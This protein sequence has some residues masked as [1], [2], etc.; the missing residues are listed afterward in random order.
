MKQMYANEKSTLILVSLLKEFGIKKI[1][2]SPGTTNLSFVA[3]LQCD[4]F[5]E[6]YSCVDERSAAYMAVGMAAESGEPVVITCTGATASRNYIPALTEA[7]YRKLPILAVTGTQNVRRVGQLSSQLIDRSQV[8][9][10]IVRMSVD[11]PIMN[12]AEDLQDITVML[13]KALNALT[14]NGGGPVH[15]NLRTQYTRDFSISELPQVR[16]IVRLGYADIE[17]FPEIPHG[18]IGVFVGSH[19]TFS[20]E[21]TK[22]ID[23]FCASKDAV[24]FCDH[25][26]GYYGDYKVNFSLPAVQKNYSCPLLNL[27]L[28]IHLGEISAEYGTL[29]RLNGC[30]EVWRVSPD[31]EIRDQFRKLKYVFEIDES[32]FFSYYTDDRD[33]RDDE[34]R[35]Y[36]KACHEE[37]ESMISKIPQLPFSNVWIASVLTK[38]LPYGSSLHLGILNST[39]AWNLFLLPPGVTS[40]ANVG[41]F[42][43]DGGV[44][45]LI[46]ASLTNPEKLY[47]GIVGDLAFFYDM[48]SLG[49][50]HVGKNVRLL[51][52]NNGKGTEFRNFYHTG[53]LF[54]DKADEYIAAGGHFGNKSANLVKDYSRDLGFEYITAS[55]KDEFLAEYKQFVDPVIGSHS[56][57]FEV[58][59][60]NQD[61]SD[62]LE[63]M[64]NI[65]SDAQGRN[66]SK[67]KIIMNQAR[68]ILGK[69][70]IAFFK[71]ILN[72]K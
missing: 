55:T 18:R 63:A 50:R 52:V 3:S 70:G 71:K 72:H 38:E 13:N 58:F 14:S 62:A 43:I 49:N 27:D 61:E 24:V 31:G 36:L 34:G 53:S 20:L 42:G 9:R 7:Y 60:N 26:S 28:C 47:F 12:D 35:Q 57:V 16:K 66:A 17:K 30:K 29:A 59:T 45:S 33:D 56:I 25:T 19:N 68:K 4:P 5:F 67:N 10:D 21:L 64:W 22:A 46:G 69:E 51:I 48:N 6:M 65:K 11:I 40:F 8:Q 15:I 2:A 39:R 37:Y 54:G 44:S 1:I 41:G 32:D 23:K